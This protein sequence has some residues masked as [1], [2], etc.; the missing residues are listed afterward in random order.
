MLRSW[1]LLAT[2]ALLPI[3]PALAAE[4]VLNG[5][6]EY[7]SPDN[8]QHLHDWT[9]VSGGSTFAAPGYGAPDPETG[10]LGYAVVFGARLSQ[11]GATLSQAIA[12]VPGEQYLFSFD[13]HSDN[14]VPNGFVAS[15][16]DQTV[17]SAI[18]GPGDEG[19][20]DPNP[21]THYSYVVTAVS[22]ST[23]ISFYGYDEEDWH[24]LDNVSVT[25]V[26]EPGTAALLACGAAGL[27]LSLRRARRQV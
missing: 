22:A 24:W 19:Y 2:A 4:L 23:T 6:F 12:T 1:P 20:Y 17:F 25:P 15:F 3:G 21:Y 18:Y 14:S 10:Q 5:G 26:P 13:F 16:G 11:G 8:N 7:Q 9:L 27:T